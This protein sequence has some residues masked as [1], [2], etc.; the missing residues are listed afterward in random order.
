MRGSTYNDGG[1]SKLVIQWEF[2]LEEYSF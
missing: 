2:E 1:K